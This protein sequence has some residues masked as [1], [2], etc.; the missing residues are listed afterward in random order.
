MLAKVAAVADYYDC[1]NVLYI[2][3]DIW[4][5]SLDE[6]A[7]NLT[8]SRDLAFWLW[9]AWFFKIPEKF[10]QYTLILMSRSDG[11]IAFPGLPIPDQVIESINQSRQEVIESMINLLYKTR[12]AFLG[13]KKACWMFECKSIM[14]GALT[15]HIQSS[16]F[17]SPRPYEH[18]SETS[19]S[20]PRPSTYLHSC[21][22][23]T[24]TSVFQVVKLTHCIKEL[25]LDSFKAFGFY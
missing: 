17:L 21:S 24:F 23:S 3:A 15:M 12:E 18:L 22:A 25:D 19:M 13:G 20:G 6:K 10:T 5:G 2:M 16:P 8:C 14:Y 11:W 9:V 1:K 7:P 4:V